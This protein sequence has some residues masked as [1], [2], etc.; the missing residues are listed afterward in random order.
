MTFDSSD[1]ARPRDQITVLTERFGKRLTKKHTKRPDGSWVTEARDDGATWFSHETREIDGV[2]SLYA[3]LREVAQDRSKLV[4]RA[5]LGAVG[6]ESIAKTGYTRR[7][8]SDGSFVPA[9]R[10]WVLFDID[11]GEAPEGYDI[12]AR[13]EE[14]VDWVIKERFPSEFQGVRV[15]WQLSSSAGLKSPNAIKLH[16][17]A[18]LSRP[19]GEEELKAWRLNAGLPVDWRVFLDVQ[20]H[21]LAD[22][23]F[24]G[25]HDPCPIR[26]GIT[27]GAR[28]AIE[29][30]E[31][32]IK[33]AVAIAREKGVTLSGT[34]IG[35]TVGEI[36][37]QI[38]DGEGGK[39]FHEVIIA[40]QMKWARTT[41]PTQY[42]ATRE[43]L[44][45]DIRTAARNAT[46]RKGR[47]AGDVEGY[48][49]DRRLDSEI[50]GAINRAAIRRAEVAPDAEN[51]MA[52]EDAEKATVSLKNSIRRFFYEALQVPSK[53]RVY[54]T[55]DAVE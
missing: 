36:L 42:A 45:A 38:G 11:E 24:V 10:H 30:P 5:R 51:F 55:L 6:A 48:L 18:W 35:A 9:P 37:A 32:D 26:W 3:V 23:S 1:D 52:L 34:V 7:K 39:G 29:V 15:V 46:R 2:D 40:S 22:P 31:I 28:G 12:R 50:D 25:A 19:L 54:E 13:P 44:K 43:A 17:W 27:A 49:S 21:F 41:P 53:Q 16:L 33:K 4:I 14:L 8:K 47:S 20:E